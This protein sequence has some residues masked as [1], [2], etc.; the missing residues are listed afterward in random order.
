MKRILKMNLNHSLLFAGLLLSFYAC[1]EEE[2]VFPKQEGQEVIVTETRPTAKP[3]NLTLV[4]AFNQNVEI[5]WP[6][7]SDR[8]VKAQIKYKDGSEKVL[9]VTKFTDPVVIH[10]NELKSYDFLL[11]YFTADGTPSK[12]TKTVL[13][14]RPFEADFKM[15]NLS[16]NPI[17]GGVEFIFPKT[18]DREILGTISYVLNGKIMNHSFKSN[19]TDTVRV[20]DLVDDT[21]KIDFV[22]SL[23]DELWK[24]NLNTQKELAPGMLVYKMILPSLTSSM[25]GNN[26]ILQWKNVT[27]DPIDIKCTYVGFSGQKTVTVTKNTDS[28]GSLRIDVGGKPGVLKVVVSSEGGSSPEQSLLLYAP[29]AKNLWSATVS[30]IE[31]NEGEANGKGSSLI[32]GDINTYWHSTWSSGNFNYPHWFII[33]FGKVENFTKFGMIR[34]H[35]NTTGGFK[36][37]NVEVSVD[38]T[39]WTMVGK[40]LTFN[41]AEATATWQDY[42]ITPTRAQYVRIT[43][44]VPFTA[45]A[46]STHLAEFRAFDL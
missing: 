38:G 4:S 19:L 28:N 11:Q 22:L 35:N 21:K 46:T 17:P 27:G 8:V 43:M 32:D 40:D 44:T 30:S 18:S 2:L 37:F 39:N 10:L 42:I 5:H 36:T 26:A 20:G 12:V 9:E 14:P 41:S 31:T 16:V 7:L 6:A 34:R 45:G 1:K 3:T 13:T 23:N 15:S 24:R 29:I 25:D 33:N